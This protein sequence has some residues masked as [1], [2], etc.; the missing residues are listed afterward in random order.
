MVDFERVISCPLEAGRNLSDF[1]CGVSAIDDWLSRKG[2]VLHSKFR[3]RIVTYRHDD[4]QDVLGF[5]SLKIVLEREK[6]VRTTFDARPWV[7][8]A[9]FPALHLEFVGVCARHQGQGLGTYMLMECIERFCMIAETTGVPALT[10]QPLTPELR[11]YYAAR[12]FVEYGSSGGM[13][14][15]A[16]TALAL[17]RV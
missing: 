11:P 16:Q 2:H 4:E 3:S 14:L 9:T 6:E 8:N 15:T 10:L 7:L 12:N 13:L 5:Y 17:R 1:S